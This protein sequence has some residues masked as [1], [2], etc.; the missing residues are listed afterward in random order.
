MGALNF[1]FWNILKLARTAENLFA[2]NIYFDISGTAVIASGS[3][4]E[5]EF[6]WT[7]RNVGTEYLLLG[8]DF[9]QMSLAQ[10]LAAFD[11]LDLTPTEKKQ[12]R[13]ENAQKLFGL[14]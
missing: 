12:I 13:Y 3:P 11:R 8:S 2:N 4:I 1:R 6:I 9:P 5:Q 10:N 14:K 7:L